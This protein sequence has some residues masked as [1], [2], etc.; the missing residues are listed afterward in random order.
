MFASSKPD[1]VRICYGTKWRTS[2]TACL[3]GDFL[4]LSYYYKA[5]NIHDNET[6]REIIL[7]LNYRFLP[8]N[9]CYFM[10]TSGKYVHSTVWCLTMGACETRHQWPAVQSLSFALSGPEEHY[11]NTV[12]VFTVALHQTCECVV[13]ICL[14][15]YCFSCVSRPVGIL[16]FACLLHVHLLREAN[17]FMRLFWL[18]LR[19][20]MCMYHMYFVSNLEHLKQKLL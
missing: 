15:N 16:L 13:T 4:N 19:L 1:V 9:I 11:A 18:R 14:L 8:L 6:E 17:Y 12:V 7:C 5:W 10:N 3:R 20:H 2:F